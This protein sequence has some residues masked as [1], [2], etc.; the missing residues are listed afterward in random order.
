MSDNDLKDRI[1]I[2]SKIIEGQITV[3]NDLVE[4]VSKLE[5]ELENQSEFNQKL[6]LE[7]LEVKIERGCKCQKKQ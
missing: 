7:L 4:Q 3:I 1:T 6:R 5:T 2:Q